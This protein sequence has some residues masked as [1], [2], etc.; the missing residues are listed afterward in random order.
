M[1]NIRLIARIDV[2]NDFVIKG[3]H[4]EGLRKIG[5]PNKMAVKYYKEGIDEIIFMDVVASLYGRNNLFHIIEKAC[6]DVFIPITVGGGLR[7]IQDIEMALKSGADK[8]AINTGAI[9]KPQL[10]TEAAK[11]FGSQ[12]IVGSIEAK[13]KNGSWEAYINN[14]RETTEKDAI[15]WAKQIEDLGA[16]EIFITSVDREGTRKGF[17]IDLIKRIMDVVS[18][19]VIACGGG[20][21]LEHIKDLIFD[22]NVDA[23][24]LASVL[25]YDDYSIREIKGFLS[26]NNIQI[27]T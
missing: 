22:S 26:T 11:N 9:K 2:K 25:H 13:K 23:V 18:I 16:G 1:R 17:D 21:R 8:V 27:R 19:P 7:S 14:G 24:A 15:E 3:I 5:D 6:N 20:G 12:C 10:V 4:L